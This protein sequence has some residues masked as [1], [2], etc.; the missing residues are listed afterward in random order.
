[1]KQKLISALV[2]IA[3]ALVFWYSYQL[4]DVFYNL[5]QNAG[6]YI[7]AHTFL[8][9]AVFIGLAALSA[10]LAPF[11]SVPLVP[12]AVIIWGESLTLILLLGG[13][14]LGGVCSYILARFV[15]YKFIGKLTS[16]RQLEAYRQKIKPSS[17]F[18]YVLLFRIIMPSEIPGY[19]LGLLRYPFARYLIITFIAELPVAIFTVMAS[20]AFVSQK[21][22]EFIILIAIMVLGTGLVIHFLSKKQKGSL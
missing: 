3:V 1:M 17:E 7:A 14:I 13:W 8:G 10:M 6:Y 20:E 22:L 21:K 18:W 9:A 16:L 5:V 11:S 19:L 4:Q 15:G 2:I 12:A